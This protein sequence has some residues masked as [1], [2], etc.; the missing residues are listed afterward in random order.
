MQYRRSR[1]AGGVYF[2][3]LV[4][5]QRQTL[6]TLPENIQRLRTAFQRERLKRTFD[7]EAI[8]ILPDHL[9][10]IWRLP[11][12][13]DDFST[14]WSNIKRY[15]SIGCV[16]VDSNLPS[17]R[18]SKR[19]KAVW[20]RRFWEHTISDEQDWRNHLDYIHYN[21]VKHGLVKSPKNWPYSSFKRCVDKGWYDENWGKYT[22]E[23]IRGMDFE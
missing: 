21:P 10:T 11:A 16:G 19:E 23:H 12:G 20:Q 1:E 6:L 7:M 18:Q 5:Y 15:F 22:P 3:T 4:T 9:H 13:D 2:F 14:R 8:V 17:P